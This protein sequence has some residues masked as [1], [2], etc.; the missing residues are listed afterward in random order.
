MNAE[1]ARIWFS[2]VLGGLAGWINLRAIDPD[3]KVPPRSEMVATIDEAVAWCQRWD[4]RGLNLYAGL[5]RR[6]EA[7]DDNGRID[8]SERNLAGCQVIW[9]DLD[10]GTREE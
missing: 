4:D 8:A 3:Q 5:A 2:T 6:G 1:D 7:K 9:A 10:D